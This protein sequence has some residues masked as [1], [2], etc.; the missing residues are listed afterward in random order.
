MVDVHKNF[1]C[2]KIN[3]RSVVDDKVYIYI[4]ELVHK[5]PNN[6]KTAP[7]FFGYI[8]LFVTCNYVPCSF[9]IFPNHH[10][11]MS[12]SFYCSKGFHIYL[13]YIQLPVV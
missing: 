2:H 7:S 12:S 13:L 3:E 8:N 1:M 9:R 4:V 11:L 5:L 6:R 10:L